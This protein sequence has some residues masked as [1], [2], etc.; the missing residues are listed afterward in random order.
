[1]AEAR[2]LHDGLSLAVE[3]G[4]M[5]SIVMSDCNPLVQAIH[6]GVVPHWSIYPWWRGITRLLQQ[7]QCNIVHIYREGNSV[8]DCLA[9]FTCNPNSR[10]V[11]CN[12]RDLPCNARG[13]VMVDKLGLPSYRH[14]SN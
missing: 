11:F 10:R 3:M 6:K 12:V 13:E 9:K 5:I 14:F 8:A 7:L 2:A 1:M 4:F